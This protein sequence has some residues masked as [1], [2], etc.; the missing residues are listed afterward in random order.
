MSIDK[1]K[2]KQNLVCTHSGILPI[3]KK[4]GNS[5][6]CDNMD[7]HVWHN[8]KWK[9]RQILHMSSLMRGI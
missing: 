9:K 4:E 2:N 3:L 8:S 7:G 1:W 6:I 5:V